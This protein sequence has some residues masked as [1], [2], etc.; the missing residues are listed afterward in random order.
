MSM[1]VELEDGR[2][3]DF[4]YDDNT[5]IDNYLAAIEQITTHVFHQIHK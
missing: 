3:F 5:I 2:E 4:E 1:K